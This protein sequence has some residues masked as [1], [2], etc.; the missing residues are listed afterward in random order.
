ERVQHL[1]GAGVVALVGL[2]PEREIRVVGIQAAVLQRVRVELVIQSD[3]AAFLTQV[4]QIAAVLG[5]P[6]DRFA[7]LRPAIAALAAERVT[8]EAFAVYAH[9]RWFGRRWLAQL[10]GYVLPPI[11]QSGEA[12]DRRSGR[13]VVG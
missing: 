1:G 12:D 2:V 11:D 3:A 7:Q 9:Q 6:L 8:G 5:D 4:Q 10:E 13:I